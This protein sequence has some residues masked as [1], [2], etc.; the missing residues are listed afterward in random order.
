[1]KNKRKL[2]KQLMTHKCS[3]CS[4]K[5]N[6]RNHY[7]EH[8]RMHIGEKSHKCVFC[9]YSC[10]KKTN[11]NT[12]VKLKH[13]KKKKIEFPCPHCD[14]VTHSSMIIFHHFKNHLKNL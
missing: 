5:T 8:Y 12:H 4:F 7:L 13:F 9:D 10:V 1:M 2:T 11:L 6:R 3:K 14:F